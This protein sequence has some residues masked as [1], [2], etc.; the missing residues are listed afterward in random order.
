MPLLQ[1]ILKMFCCLQ[2]TLHSLHSPIQG[3]LERAGSESQ[4]KG[5]LDK[6]LIEGITSNRRSLSAGA[7]KLE[8]PIDTYNCMSAREDYQLGT[9]NYNVFLKIAK[10][11]NSLYF[12]YLKP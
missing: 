1:Q 5:V 4:R 7:I 2:R 10:F 12:K 6:S 8:P 9:N 11:K 3:N